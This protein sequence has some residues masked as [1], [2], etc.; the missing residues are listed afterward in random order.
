MSLKSSAPF[1]FLLS[2]PFAHALSVSYVAFS[3]TDPTPPQVREATDLTKK[4]VDLASK[5][6]DPLSP[7]TSLTMGIVNVVAMVT[8][9][10]RGT[11]CW[12]RYLDHL[13]GS[14]CHD[15]D[16]SSMEPLLLRVILVS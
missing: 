2:L 7:P 9:I 13:I 1:P 6:A 5:V 14:L 16:I 4:V 10:V 15:K 3:H 8:D 11:I 12:R